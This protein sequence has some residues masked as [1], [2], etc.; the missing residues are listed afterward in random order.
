MK[1]LP[2]PLLCL[3][4]VSLCLLSVGAQTRKPVFAVVIDENLSLLRTKPSLFADS[5]QRIR[6]GRRVQVLGSFENDGVRFLR[7]SAPPRSGWIQS[8]ALAGKFRSNDE[9]RL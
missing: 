6:R 7:I 3:T 1:I 4:V 2:L 8:D 5:A 9:E